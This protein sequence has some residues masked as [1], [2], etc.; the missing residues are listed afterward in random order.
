[1]R[2]VASVVSVSDKSKS[3]KLKSRRH[4]DWADGTVATFKHTHTHANIRQFREA[5][6]LI[7][8]HEYTVKVH[9][10]HYYIGLISNN[11]MVIIPDF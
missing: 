7:Y 9:R 3:L 8:K 1:M 2:I 6:E 5:V 4:S 11:H 10:Q